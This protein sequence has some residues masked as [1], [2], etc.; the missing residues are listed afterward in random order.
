[1]GSTI[2][3]YTQRSQLNF[4]EVITVFRLMF[5]RIKEKPVT[6]SFNN[7]GMRL[8]LCLKLSLHLNQLTNN[9]HEVYDCLTDELNH[10]CLHH[11]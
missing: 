6:D 3:D 5:I 10:Q 8:F 1:M 2:V 11:S 7:V 4:S 9:I